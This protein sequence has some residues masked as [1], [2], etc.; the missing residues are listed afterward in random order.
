MKSVLTS[1]CWWRVKIRLEFPTNEAV[2]KFLLLVLCSTVASQASRG[3]EES[4]NL[5]ARRKD[6][7]YKH[8]F[9]HPLCLYSGHICWPLATCTLQHFQWCIY[10]SRQL[11]GEKYECFRLEEIDLRNLRTLVK[12]IYLGNGKPE[13]IFYEQSFL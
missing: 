9:I 4:H 12:V 3:S 7:I 2:Y 10:S 5:V 11:C 8:A 6:H 13:I 1:I